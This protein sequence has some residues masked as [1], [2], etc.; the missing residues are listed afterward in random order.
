MAETNPDHTN[1]KIKMDFFNLLLEVF[2]W[3]RIVAS[4]LLIGALIGFGVYISNPDSTRLIIAIIIASI[5]LLTGII[6][7]TKVW[8]KGSTMDYTTIGSHDFD[9]YDK[10]KD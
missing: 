5:G 7:A 3:I 4:P 8:R 6:W 10:E 1:K 2:G 9:K